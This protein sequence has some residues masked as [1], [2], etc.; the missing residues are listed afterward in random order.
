MDELK[1]KI[2]DLSVEVFD[3]MALEKTSLEF[4]V[5]RKGNLTKL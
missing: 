4:A 3:R 2:A 5:G 1:V